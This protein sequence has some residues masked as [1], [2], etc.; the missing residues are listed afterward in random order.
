MSVSS[1]NLSCNLSGDDELSFKG[2]SDYLRKYTYL[3]LINSLFIN[4][5]CL[6][7]TLRL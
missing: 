6:Y 3:F 1:E 5:Y 2:S 4:H 7:L